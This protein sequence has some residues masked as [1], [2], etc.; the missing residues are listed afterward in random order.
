MIQGYAAKQSVWPGQ[1]LVLHVSAGAGRFRAVFYRWVGRLVHML[2]SGWMNGEPAAQ[3]CA[4]VHWHWPPYRFTLP[5][6]WPSGVYIAHLEHPG[7]APPSLA[8]RD[9]AVLFV[10][11][12]R[13]GTLLYKLPLATYNA[14]NYAGGGCFYAHPPQSDA[15]P[16]ARLSFQRPGIGIGGPV[17][18]APDHYEASTARQTFAHW[19]ARFIRWLTRQR[20]APDFCT[21]LDIHEDPELCRGYRLL[22]GAGHDEYW[23]EPMRDG[24]EHFIDTGGNAAFFSGNLCWWRIH[25]VDAGAAMVCHQGGPE[26]ALDRW[27]Q[28]PE[29]GLAGVSYRHAGGWW[30]GP[31]S[32]DGYCVIEPDHWVFA[33]TGL[34]KGSVF[35]AGTQPPLVGYE[36]DGAPLA[37]FDR[38]SGAAELSPLAGA[39]GT[40]SGFR[41][42]AACALD[43]RWQE[44]PPR[45]PF[46]GPIH[47]ATMGISTGNGTVFT[48]ATTDWAQV[49]DRG[50]D[51]HLHTITRNVIDGLLKG[52]SNFL[53][54]GAT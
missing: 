21:D 27:H 7:A 5:R 16:G 53:S 49:L 10:V 40:R 43:E 17:F 42:L 12:G 11:R 48:A 30:D 20:Y 32:S 1:A 28:R 15:P 2:T 34:A 33:G 22:L 9:A 19:D 24:V 44:R 39:C 47:A 51:R 38:I 46:L 13:R 29:D 25:V 36:C 3:R 6:D 45:E 54:G 35:G 8:M 31:R 18:G 41:L 50:Q 4:G 52:T 14:Y 26:G 37:S 23:S